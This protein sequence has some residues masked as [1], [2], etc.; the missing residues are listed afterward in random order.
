[1]AIEV[2]K[3]FQTVIISADS[4]Q[5]YREMTI[6][7]A[8]PTA[9][10]LA[11][12]PHFFI[13][14]LS[15]HE[16]YSAGDFEREALTKINELFLEKDVLVLVGGS[17]LF[18]NAVC[19]GLDDLPKPLPGIRDK[20]NQRY[21]DQGLTWL[22]TELKRVDPAYYAVA[23]IQNPQ[24]LIRALEV[25]ESTGKPFS[26]FRK[27]Q[28][29]SR[30]FNCLMVGLNTNREIVY[31]QINKRVDHMMQ[32]GLLAEVQDLVPY[33]HLPPL[34]TVGYVELFAYLDHKYS[35]E[36]AVEKIKQHTRQFAKR[37]ITWF[38]KD[39]KIHWFEPSEVQRII[40]FIRSAL[41]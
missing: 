24:R 5:F 17:G 40:A 25:F 23:D 35:L 26:Y 38:K 29:K 39:E 1:M 15:I 34:L 37:Q 11:A 20:L 2:A 13:N 30:P 41:G 22:Q 8:K 19:I 32:E 21:R 33:R 6:G 36:T 18:V 28:R 14:S 16:N 4:R 31:H 27:E 9:E 10:E 7:T 12:V 3:A